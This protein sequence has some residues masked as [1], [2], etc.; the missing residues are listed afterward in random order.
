MTHTVLD[1]V[2][3]RSQRPVHGSATGSLTGKTEKHLGGSTVPARLVQGQAE[4]APSMEASPGERLMWKTRLPACLRMVARWP[5]MSTAHDRSPQARPRQ[6]VQGSS[7]HHALPR[8]SCP[9][10]RERSSSIRVPQTSPH[11]DHGRVGGAPTL[12]AI[13]SRW[14]TGRWSKK[15]P[16][17]ERPRESRTHHHAGPSFRHA[18]TE[19]STLG[20]EIRHSYVHGC[21]PRGTAS[22]SRRQKELRNGF[23]RRPP[24]VRTRRWAVPH[25]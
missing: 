24:R 22:P 23:G 17:E 8:R 3:E 18:Q 1:V 11:R 12:N 9:G 2:I 21:V 15:A 20:G 6:S 10:P 7:K 5:A 14:R 25:S 16:N 4:S 19:S 13:R